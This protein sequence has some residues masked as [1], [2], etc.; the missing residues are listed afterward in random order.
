MS[1]RSI[2]TYFSENIRPA[3]AGTAEAI[4]HV[5]KQLP[6]TK[7]KLDQVERDRAKPKPPKTAAQIGSE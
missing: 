4:R 2:K 7:L 3:P 1:S 6:W 5:V